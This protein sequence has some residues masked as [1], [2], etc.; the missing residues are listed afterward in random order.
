MHS[1]PEELR[2]ELVDLKRQLAEERARNDA[3]RT[4]RGA[5]TSPAALRAH[6]GWGWTVL[7]AVLITVGTVLAPVAVVSVWVQHELTDTAY[8]VDTFAPLATEPAVQNFIAD[9]AVSVIESEVNIDQLV[10]D[11]FSG[12]DELELA[13]RARAALGLL[14]APAASGA[15]GLISSTV[16]Q[17]V[18]SDAFA[19]IWKETLTV[20]HTQ[21]LKTAHG[22][23]DAAISVAQDHELSLQLGPIVEAVKSRLVDDGFALA[24]RIP[25]VSNTITIAETDSVGIVLTVYRVAVAVGLWLPWVSLALIAAGVLVARRRAVA[26]LW[27]SGALLASMLL[28]GSGVALGRDV[29]ALAVASSVPREAAIVLYAGILGFASNLIVVVGVLAATVLVLT[30]LAGPWRWARTLR[31]TVAAGF[32]RVRRLAGQRGI[33]TERDGEESRPAEGAALPRA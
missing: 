24:D 17:F 5:A 18:R 31:D 26:L 27:G 12:L 15:K 33:T 29:F 8:F 16:S 2:A 14:Q 23:Q 13:P 6:R 21:F 1:T 28:A 32:T 10:D 3:G 19:Q 11:L 30:A 4:A 25:V 9:E 7:A 22:Q 20:A